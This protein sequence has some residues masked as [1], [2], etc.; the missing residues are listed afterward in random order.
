MYGLVTSISMYQKSVHARES[1]YVEYNFVVLKVPTKQKFCSVASD[2][3]HCPTQ[4]SQKGRFAAVNQLENPQLGQESH[5]YLHGQKGL[6][7]WDFGNMWTGHMKG[8]L[9]PV[10]ITYKGAS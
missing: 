10:H 7:H 2:H 9:N 8:L 6:L 5:Y 1:L 4:Q 3:L